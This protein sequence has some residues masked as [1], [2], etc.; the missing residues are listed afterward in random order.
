MLGVGSLHTL[1]GAAAAG[2]RCGAEN[3]GRAPVPRTHCMLKRQP[4][5]MQNIYVTIDTL[6]CPLTGVAS[7][8]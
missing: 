5:C 3:L 7:A 8:M 1:L 4:P 6:A 2:N